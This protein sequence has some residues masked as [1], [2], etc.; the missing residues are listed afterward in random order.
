M[1]IQ[2]KMTNTKISD[3]VKTMKN[4]TVVGIDNVNV[5]M[6]N[7]EIKDEAEFLN[8]LTDRQIDV[9]LERLEEQ[10]ELLKKNGKEYNEIENLLRDVKQ[11]R[12]SSREILKQYLPNL[13]T[14]TLANVLSGIIMR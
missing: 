9:I 7:V 2:I 4:M 8:N 13:L 14:G 11:N 3:K 12:F 10:A 6:D 5:E 1:N